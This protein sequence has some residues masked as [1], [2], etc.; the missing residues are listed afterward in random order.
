MH[1]A[2][3]SNIDTPTLFDELWQGLTR[4]GFETMPTIRDETIAW[5][6]W[7]ITR[8]EDI[9]ANILV[10]ESSQVLDDDWLA[11]LGAT[12][13]DTGNAMSD[14]EILQLSSSLDMDALR[15]YR[16]EVGKRTRG[17]VSNLSFEDLKRKV[18]PDGIKRILAEGGVTEHKDSIWLLDFWGRKNIAGILLMPFTRH[19][20]IHVADCFKWKEIIAA[21]QARRKQA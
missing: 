2:E 12:I 4:A 9:T 11:S 1:A 18:K 15:D 13:R 8:I 10:A 14:D 20:I 3:V 7:H 17:I 19:Q 5:S 16:I 6:I 21:K